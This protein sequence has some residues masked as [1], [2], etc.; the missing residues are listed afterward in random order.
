MFGRGK[1]AEEPVSDGM[2]TPVMETPQPQLPPQVTVPVRNHDYGNSILVI[3]LAIITTWIG[4]ELLFN[5]EADPKQLGMILS[6]GILFGGMIQMV[7]FFLAGAYKRLHDYRFSTGMLLVLLGLGGLMRGQELAEN[8]NTIVGI[9]VLCMGVF[10]LQA[11]IMLNAL[12]NMFWLSTAIMSVIVLLSG[13][14]SLSGL[15]LFE[16]LQ[17]FSTNMM[18]IAGGACAVFAYTVVGLVI[19]RERRR[20][21]KRLAREMNPGTKWEEDDRYYYDDSGRKIQDTPDDFADERLAKEEGN[22]MSDAEFSRHFNNT[23]KKTPK[24]GIELWTKTKY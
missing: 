21:K 4:L 23:M 11:A 10:L 2:E 14:S 15:R 16:K 5:K 1:H 3:G 9:L 24:K 6:V 22:S 7:G 20:E 13:V 17:S 19:F 12:C 18:A 8:L